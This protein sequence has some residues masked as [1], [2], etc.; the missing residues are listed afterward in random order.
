M[1]SDVFFTWGMVAKVGLGE[2]TSFFFFI[3][4]RG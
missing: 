1:A 2:V 4:G 3:H